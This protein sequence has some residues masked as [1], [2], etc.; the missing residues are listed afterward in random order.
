MTIEKKISCPSLM[1]RGLF[2]PPPPLDPRMMQ[3]R[4][5]PMKM[6]ALTMGTNEEA[7]GKGLKRCREHDRGR[8]INGAF[9]LP[10]DDGGQ[11]RPSSLRALLP[12][13][14]LVLVSE[15]WPKA[16]NVSP[17]VRKQ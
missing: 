15:Q 16:S 4:K 2:T 3:N 17:N 12:P 14:S 11:S 9:A 7:D 1:L 13:S 10:S 5:L 6:K 8:V